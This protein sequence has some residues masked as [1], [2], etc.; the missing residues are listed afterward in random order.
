MFENKIGQNRKPMLTVEIRF[1]QSSVKFFISNFKCN[2]TTEKVNQ[3]SRLP[4]S[5]EN[6]ANAQPY[7]TLNISFN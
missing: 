2:S 4:L 6:S 3:Q 1:V 7:V 5:V